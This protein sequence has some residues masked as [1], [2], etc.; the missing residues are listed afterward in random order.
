MRILSIRRSDSW[1][2]ESGTR[3]CSLVNFAGAVGAGCGRHCYYDNN[4][5]YRLSMFVIFSDVQLR[6]TGE[7]LHDLVCSRPLKLI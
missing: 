6:L 7:T 2:C 1:D 5:L 3:G 4:N